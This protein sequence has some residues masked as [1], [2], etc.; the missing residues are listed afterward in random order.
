[1]RESY[2]RHHPALLETTEI[3]VVLFLMMGCWF[4]WYVA[5]ERYFLTTRQ[6]V[7]AAAYLFI[8]VIAL[9]VAAILLLTR[10]SRR[11]KQW[12][13]SAIAIAHKRD[14]RLTRQ[15]WTQNSVVLGY[16]IHGQP[17]Y[18]SDQVRVMQAIVLGMTG[19]G[20]TTLLRNIIS[21]DLARV[22]GPPEA[23]HRIPMVIFDGKGDLEF[24][25]DLLPHVHRRATT[26]APA[27]ES[28]T[29]RSLGPL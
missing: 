24:F 5:R 8:A 4:A 7:E 18:W 15:A 16:D 26:S 6:L 2:G 29:S 17:W 9:L 20:K 14:E 12:P 22:V 21:Q 19:T 11:E 23:K 28:R 10:R 13:H 25:Q 1:M 27:F 3:V